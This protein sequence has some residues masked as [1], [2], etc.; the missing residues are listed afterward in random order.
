MDNINNS[1]NIN[2]VDSKSIPKNLPKRI[3]PE[4]L[5]ARVSQKPAQQKEVPSASQVQPRKAEPELKHKSIEELLGKE[6]EPEKPKKQNYVD[7]VV[8]KSDKQVLKDYNKAVAY[9]RKTVKQYKRNTLKTHLKFKPV[10]NVFQKS[11]PDM[12]WFFERGKI[13]SIL[14]KI[15]M[16]INYSLNRHKGVLTA[17]IVTILIMAVIATG[18]YLAFI[19]TK[20]LRQ[21]DLETVGEINLQFDGQGQRSSRIKNIKDARFNQDLEATPVVFNNT[22]IPLYIKFYITLEIAKGKNAMGVNIR[23][24][25]PNPNLSSDEDWWVDSN[26]GVAYYLGVLPPGEHMELFQTFQIN[27]DESLETAW[28]NKYVVATIYVD[29]C[30]VMGAGQEFPP[31]W[32]PYW[33]ELI[34]ET[35]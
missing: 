5:R 9:Y 19:I 7:N 21:E 8:H 20:N 13:K 23:D 29:V 12:L 34:K 4:M 22:N 30:Q 15:D 6:F 16:T 33:Q 2:N 10:K 32:S 11:I 28:Q 14:N 35:Y 26:D 31:A 3:S 25:T 18:V 17:I 1:S 27:A 24:L